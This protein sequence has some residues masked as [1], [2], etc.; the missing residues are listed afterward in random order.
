MD[1]EYWVWGTQTQQC[2]DTNVHTYTSFIQ[3]N[4]FTSSFLGFTAARGTEGSSTLE[5]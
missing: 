3:F 1:P 2:A 5:L 4:I